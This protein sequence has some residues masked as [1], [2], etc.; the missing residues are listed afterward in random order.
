MQAMALGVF[1][2][3]FSFLPDLN[4]KLKLL[5]NPKSKKG[6]IVFDRILR[7]KRP[8]VIGQFFHCLPVILIS[9]KQAQFTGHIP[10]MNIQRTIQFTG[11][12]S[13]PEAEIYPPVIPADHPPEEHIDPF[14]R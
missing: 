1:C 12:E 6:I 13:M 9:L 7:V 10:G 11:M 4:V 2:L 3:L 5:K 14:G 8:Q